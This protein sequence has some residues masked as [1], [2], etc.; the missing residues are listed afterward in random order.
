MKI[1]RTVLLFI[2]ETSRFGMWPDT[3]I[4][5]LIIVCTSVFLCFKKF[6]HRMLFLGCLEGI[7]YVIA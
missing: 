1:C 4:S 5:F 6:E 2:N 7:F 3:F